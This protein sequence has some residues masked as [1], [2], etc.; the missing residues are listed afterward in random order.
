[1]VEIQLDAPLLSLLPDWYRE[2]LDY[3]ELC[4]TEQEQFEQ[5]AQE[6]TTVARNLFFQTMDQKATEQW[7]KLLEIRA[8]STQETLELRRKRVLNRVSIRPP[9]TLGFLGQKLNELIGKNQWSVYVDYPNY[10][11]Y[12]LSSARQKDYASEVACTIETMKPAHIVY[13]NTP[14]VQSMLAIC[15]RMQGNHLLWQ[16]RLGQWKLAVHPFADKQDMGV[17]PMQS[18][19]SIQP[20]LLCRVASF[21]MEHIAAARLNG[22]VVIKELDISVVEHVLTISY[23]VMP[24]QVTSITQI[25]LLDAQNTVLTACIVYVPVS[26][27]VQIKHNIPIQER[28]EDL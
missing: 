19:A 9:F 20:I 5:L 4:R 6:I 12:I 21:L 8:D 22:T 28:A 14:V 15:Q 25:E 27:T 3:R 17:L 10:T 23:L 1:M 13:V 7:E 26:A 24:H 2:I 11:L 18:I 16:Y